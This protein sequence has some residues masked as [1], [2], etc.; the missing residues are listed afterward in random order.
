MLE[1]ITPS[2]PK[3]D[4]VKSVFDK[5]SQ[6]G[7]QAYA[8]MP[9]AWNQ[10][11]TD[12]DSRRI[13]PNNSADFPMD[14]FKVYNPDSVTPPP[15]ATLQDFIAAG[16]HTAVDGD[17]NSDPTGK[18]KRKDWDWP[19]PKASFEHDHD[20]PEDI[21]MRRLGPVFQW[22]L[23]RATITLN[24]INQALDAAL[25]NPGYP[26][27]D[28]KPQPG[29]AAAKYDAAVAN[30]VSFLKD[31]GDHEP[32]E[33]HNPKDPDPKLDP[34][35]SSPLDPK[36]PGRKSG[37]G[38]ATKYLLVAPV[39]FEGRIKAARVILHWNPHS[40]SNGVPIPHRPSP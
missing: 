1:N 26:L 2:L 38:K 16:R 22:A 33:K 20:N 7:I 8:W 13:L 6:D 15:Y 31:F 40:S 35:L 9:P 25:D 34:D 24:D 12:R 29:S 19:N 30:Y 17:Q 10:L 37:Y 36:F 18:G 39:I 23:L 28:F 32:E 3:Q 21:G 5:A 4:D 27:E 14:M 11:L